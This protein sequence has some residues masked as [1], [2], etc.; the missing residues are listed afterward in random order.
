MITRGR[1]E[2]E[3]EELTGR[4]LRERLVFDFDA[5]LVTP[6]GRRWAM[7]LELLVAGLGQPTALGSD[8]RLGPHLAG[9]VLDGPLLGQR[10]NYSDLVLGGS[11]PTMG[12]APAG[13]TCCVRGGT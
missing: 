10:H 12:P 5:D 7:V 11:A 1:L 13:P 4:S 6:L 3:L 9:L 8:P 2:A